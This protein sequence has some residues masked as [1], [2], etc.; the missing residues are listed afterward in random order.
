MASG[1]SITRIVCLVLFDP[2][3]PPRQPQPAYSRGISPTLQ[4][5]V[6]HHGSGSISLMT[7][8]MVRYH[9][10]TLAPS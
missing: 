2:E 10:V 8:T 3:P 6:Q 1:P 5:S 7:E 4:E 9:A